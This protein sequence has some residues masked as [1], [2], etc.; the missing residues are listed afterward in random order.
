[1]KKSLLFL[2]LAIAMA[3]MGCKKENDNPVDPPHD[4][5]GDGLFV[6]NEGTFTYANSSLSF[7]DPE[8][9][10]VAN[11]LFFRVNNAP[12]GDVG[13]SL[14]LLGDDLYIVVNNS[15]YIYKVNAK[16]LLYKA[17]LEGFSSPHYML[18]I[19]ENKAYVS[20][21]VRTGIWVIDMNTFSHSKFIETGNT[22]E[23]M[24]KVGDE[25]FVSNWS[26]YYTNGATSKNSIQIIDCVNDS[27][28]A[29]IAVAQEPGAMVVDKEGQIWVI[30]SGNYMGEQDP[31]LICIDAATHEIVKRFDFTPGADY[32]SGLAIDGEGE[33][34]YFMNG[35]MSA[36]SV[37]KMSIYSD[38][39]PANPFITSGGK[40]FYS[41]KVDPENGDVYVTNAKNYV[42]NGDVERY[43]SNGELLSTF[44]TGIIPAYMLFN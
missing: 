3:F 1:M 25:V 42:M 13:Q 43:S 29:E 37:Y 35:G 39:I 44:T 28:V 17:K 22:T 38:E 36:L 32:P 9:D 41:L 24:V 4:L 27:L 26:N 8:A 10:T 2:T 5:I 19:D 30:C 14:T 12:I 16:S 6:L 18:S 7:Y 23:A 40:V 11:N 20:D 33:N 15:K 31:A 21:L 34:I